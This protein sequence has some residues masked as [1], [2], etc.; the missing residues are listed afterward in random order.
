LVVS[1]HFPRSEGQSR[2]ESGE[3]T[4]RLT[5][6][7]RSTHCNLQRENYRMVVGQTDAFGLIPMVPERCGGFSQTDPRGGT[8]DH[9]ATPTAYSS[10]QRARAHY[11]SYCHRRPNGSSIALSLRRECPKLAG[12]AA[13]SA[14]AFF[15]AGW[16]SPFGMQNTLIK[17][18][19]CDQ[20]FRV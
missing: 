19:R 12:G 7:L 11:Q 8:V 5:R 10:T 13:L 4:M 14:H 9:A 17:P 2:R 3:R 15:I 1:Q 18:R 6:R 16:S 20:P